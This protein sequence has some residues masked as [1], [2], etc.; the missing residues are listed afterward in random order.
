[1]ASLSKAELRGRVFTLHQHLQ[2]LWKAARISPA[3][4]YADYLRRRI[5]EHKVKV[6]TRRFLERLTSKVDVRELAV[7]SRRLWIEGGAVTQKAAADDLVMEIQRI[8]LGRVAE[9]L[10]VE[11]SELTA[12][13]AG[14]AEAGANVAAAS[15][16]IPF[17]SWADTEANWR[18][19]Y[20]ELVNDTA[21]MIDNTVGWRSKLLARDLV[22]ATDPRKPQTV[23]QAAANIR[24]AMPDIAKWKAE[25]IARTETARAYGTTAHETMQRNGIKE[26]RWLTAADSPAANISPVCDFCMTA[27]GEGWVKIDDEFKWGG[28]YPPLHPN[29]R[30]DIGANTAGWLPPRPEDTLGPG[31]LTPG[32]DTFSPSFAGKSVTQVQYLGGGINKSWKMTIDGRQMVTKMATTPHAIREA[33]SERGAYIVNRAMGDLVPMPK[34]SAIQKN[35]HSKVP[36]M[37]GE[38]GSAPLAAGPLEDLQFSEFIN[39]QATAAQLYSEGRRQLLS[40]QASQD[41]RLLDTVIGNYDRHCGNLLLSRDTDAWTAIDNGLGFPERNFFLQDMAYDVNPAALGT[42]ELR[43]LETLVNASDEVRAALLSEGLEEAVINGALDRA[44]FMLQNQ[45]FLSYHEVVTG[46]W[47]VVP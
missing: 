8:M 34:V 27:A 38:P 36:F 10:D 5:T 30:C 32:W 9:Q 7:T 23:A 24:A 31:G 46:E 20:P 33:A 16:R 28:S 26:R 19:L 39:G 25:Q 37:A 11:P 41:L 29:C 35:V 4:W 45:R 15:L 6:A 17:V 21:K 47:R 22:Y 1:M 2:Y 18:E 43:A 13:L 12:A 40:Q 44:T 14:A 3:A 42:R